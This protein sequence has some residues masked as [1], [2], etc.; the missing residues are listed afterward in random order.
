MNSRER[1][2]QGINVS[3]KKGLE[4]FQDD[5]LMAAPGAFQKESRFNFNL[6]GAI[7]EEASGKNFNEL[8]KEYVT[9]T[10]HFENTCPDNIFATI[11]GRTDFYDHNIIAQAV[12]AITIDMRWRA[13]SDGLLS[14]AEDLV[15]LANI[16]LSSDYLNDS[17][18]AHLFEPAMLNNNQPSQF[19]N[20]WIVLHNRQGKIA[21]GREGFVHGGSSAVLIY[22]EEELVVAFTTN[23]T[24]DRPN[25]PVLQIADFF[26]PKPE[27]S[28]E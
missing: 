28:E 26:L 22:P 23:L 7:M 27:E 19:A 17:T 3:L 21:Y 9:D 25:S 20:G 2:W 12:N 13:P 16:Y 18:R 10:L 15:K 14:N 1:E 8:L 6:L 4:T 24:E 5:K 11:E